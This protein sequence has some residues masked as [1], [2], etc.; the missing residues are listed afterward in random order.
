M[1]YAMHVRVILS[2]HRCPLVSVGVLECC[3]CLRPPRCV[4]TGPVVRLAEMA[5]YYRYERE[6]AIVNVN[7]HILNM[8][9]ADLLF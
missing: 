4:S 2:H 5:I 9:L 8:G 7:V 6:C 1:R 3:V